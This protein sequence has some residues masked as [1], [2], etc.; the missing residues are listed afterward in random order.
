VH[1]H[2]QDLDA[3]RTAVVL[4]A[5]VPPLELVREPEH[6]AA[7]GE[8]VA[9]VVEGVEADEVGVEQGAQKLLAHGE[10]L[11]DLGR[12]EQQ[13]QEEAELDAVESLA[14]EGG[15]HHEVV[16]VVVPG[17]GLPPPSPTPAP[18]PSLPLSVSGF[19]DAH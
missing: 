3:H 18:M 4:E 7:A 8:E 16:V 5:N 11:V 13:V 1:P 15:E 17:N 14:Q 12:G 2:R 6:P 9:R 19:L 10:R